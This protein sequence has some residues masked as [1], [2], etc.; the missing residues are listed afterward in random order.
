MHN[1]QCSHWSSASGPDLRKVV[2][3]GNGREREREM[4]WHLVVDRLK[5]QVYPDIIVHRFYII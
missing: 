1:I 3:E 4:F 5:G 2:K